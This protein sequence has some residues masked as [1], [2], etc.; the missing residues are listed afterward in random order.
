MS[1]GNNETLPI[2]GAAG[3]AIDPKYLREHEARKAMLAADLP[4]AFNHAANQGQQCATAMPARP[5]IHQLLQDRLSYH[6]RQANN[7]EWLM[8]ALPREMFIPAEEALAD[9][10]LNSRPRY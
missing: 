1:R 4:Y 7:I 3:A 6:L 8:K 2:E 5:N 10:I 9:I